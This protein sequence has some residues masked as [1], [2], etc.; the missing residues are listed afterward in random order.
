MSDALEALTQRL[1][2]LGAPDPEGWALSEFHED[3][4]QTAAFV[5]LRNLWPDLIHPWRDPE[6][7]ARVP[8]SRALLDA[9][10][11]PE[12]VSRAMCVAAFE[13]VIGVLWELTG[14]VETPVGA[15]WVRLME[16]APDGKAT[17]REV[18][19]LHESLLALDPTGREGSDFL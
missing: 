15:P 5:A 2:E 10:V 12:S 3:I 14:G 9:G 4:P 7:L 17:G 11:A 1:R 16:V 6:V 8:A 13:G 19:A 18:G